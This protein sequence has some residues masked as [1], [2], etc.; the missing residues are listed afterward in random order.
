[1]DEANETTIVAGNLIFVCCSK[2]E[3]LDRVEKLTESLTVRYC[4]VCGRRHFE[5]NAEPGVYN[6][7]GTAL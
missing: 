1:M 2:P 5:G 4:R 7:R 6:S 3:N